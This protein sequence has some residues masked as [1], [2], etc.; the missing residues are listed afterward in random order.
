M[1]TILVPVDFSDA[2]RAVI[3][4]SAVLAKALSARVVL[5][6]VV[7]PPAVIAEYGALVENI[8]ELT[9]AGE[10]SA[11]KQLARLAA[12]L[13]RRGISVT[14]RHEVGAPVTL[15]VEQAKAIR[16]DYVVMGSHGHTAFFD[17]LVGSTTHGV[18]R[19]SPC[20]VVIVPPADATA[21]AT[22]KKK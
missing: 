6:A 15:I 7:Q 16:A 1:K 18:L 5:F 19:R 13:E 17:L 20:P 12:P 2:T 4:E 3:V 11:E 22:T 21:R 14:V 10:K 8:A 9:E